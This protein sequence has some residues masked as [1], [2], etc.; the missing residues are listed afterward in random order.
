MNEYNILIGIIAFVTGC[1]IAFW[2]KGKIQSQR[3]KSAERETSQILD[4]AKRT[5]ESLL[6]E[7]RLE[8]KDKLYKLLEIYMPNVRNKK[9]P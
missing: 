5:S 8:V 2:V 1:L 4:D 3:I 9:I 6:K 7:A